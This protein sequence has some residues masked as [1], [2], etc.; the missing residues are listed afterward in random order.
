[1]LYNIEGVSGTC[2]ATESDTMYQRGGYIMPLIL[3][4]IGHV[5]F[6]IWAGIITSG[7]SDRD[8]EVVAVLVFIAMLTSAISL[9]FAHFAHIF[10]VFIV[11]LVA[12]FL[13]SEAAKLIRSWR[14]GS[15]EDGED[16]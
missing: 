7:G 15:D 11:W 4:Y 12:A 10:S 6:G 9:F 16:L 14:E 3:V 1:M 13:A 2:F 5:I 8:H